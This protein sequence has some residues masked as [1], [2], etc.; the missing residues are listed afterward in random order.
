MEDAIGGLDR[1]R[2]FPVMYEAMKMRI[3]KR[4]RDEGMGQDSIACLESST[5]LELSFAHLEG[6]N[7]QGPTGGVT[8]AGTGKGVTR[9]DSTTIH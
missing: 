4:K 1:Q 9:Y 7:H 5:S 2:V 6:T 8:P 3:Y